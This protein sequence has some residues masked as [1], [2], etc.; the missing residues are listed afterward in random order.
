[1]PQ[2][3]LQQQG[4]KLRLSWRKMA[5]DI[6]SVLCGL[7]PAAMLDY[8][9]V[10]RGAMLQLAAAVRA[11]AGASDACDVQ[12]QISRLNILGRLNSSVPYRC[13]CGTACCTFAA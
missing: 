8:A 13:L 12:I 1:M 2:A 10:S 7:R 6:L 9:V 11:A 5:L 3:T 4:R